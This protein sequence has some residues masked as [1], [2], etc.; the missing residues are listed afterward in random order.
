VPDDRRPGASKRRK[1]PRRRNLM[2]TEA[3]GRD[4]YGFVSFG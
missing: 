3:M 2:R 1:T 4:S